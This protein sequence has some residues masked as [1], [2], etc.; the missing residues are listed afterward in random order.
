[1]RSISIG[2]RITI[3]MDTPGLSAIDKSWVMLAYEK[4]QQGKDT[5]LI[6]DKLLENVL[7]VWERAT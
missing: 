5:A 6:D 1:M 2:E 3:L 7:A 4:S